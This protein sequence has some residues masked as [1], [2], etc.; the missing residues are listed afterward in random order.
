MRPRKHGVTR[1]WRQPVMT[2][3]FVLSWL[4]YPFCQRP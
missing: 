3:G 4:S 1:V 2:L